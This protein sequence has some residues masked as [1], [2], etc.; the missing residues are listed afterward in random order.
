VNVFSSLKAGWH[1]DKIKQLR[2]GR[3]IVPTHVQIVISDLCNQDCHFCAYRMSAGFST[4]RFAD[5][6]GNRNPVR[7]MPTKKAKEILDDC[8]ALGVSAIEFTG[9]GEPT[10]HKDHIEIIGHA[11]SIGL[12]TGLVTNGVLL[13]DNPVFR[14]LDWLRISLDAGTPE[15]YQQIRASKAWPKVMDN[16][17]LIGSF[18][19]PYVGVGFVV[20]RENY[21]EILLACQIVKDAGIPYIRISAMFS[22][23]GASYYAG[24][25]DEI[26]ASR[27][28]AAAMQ[29]DDFKVVDFFAERVGD[30]DQG[31]PD[32]TFCGEQQFVLY[33]GGDQK[34]YTCCTNAYTTHGEIGDL[35]A[36]RF[37]DWLAGHRRY[38][39]D[40]RSCHHCQFN[41]KNRVVNF[42][43]DPAPAH[44]NFV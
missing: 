27:F 35:R 24:L 39:F 16:L 1:I 23:D 44:V 6:H 29:D 15:S 17:R 8:A 10:V 21:R 22:Q 20:T 4:E 31:R 9:G 3:D 2:D 12:Q 14:N 28:A 18:S 38:D 25:S 11:Q 26:S 30:L 43:I 33:I 41:D 7:F 36:T 32:Y 13:R 19:K 5:E 34:V 42:L 37:K 40:A